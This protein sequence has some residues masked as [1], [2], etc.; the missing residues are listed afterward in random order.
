MTG[1]PVF[2]NDDC[3]GMIELSD[4][5]TILVRAPRPSFARLFRGDSDP[6]SP[7]N[8]RLE[9]VIDF[10]DK[11]SAFLINS[12]FYADSLVEVIWFPFSLL[13]CC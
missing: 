13:R 1:A 7:I 4:I 2:K 11:P 6:D 12:S 3:W 9:N 8:M 5:M 10:A